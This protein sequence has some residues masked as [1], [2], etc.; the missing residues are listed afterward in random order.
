MDAIQA[1]FDN[2]SSIFDQIMTTQKES[3]FKGAEMLRDA[4]IEGHNPV[5]YT[6]LCSADEL[7]FISDVVRCLKRY[8][9]PEVQ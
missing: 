2:L 3:L 6:H 7:K 1:Y 4:V 5:S 9:R 8:T